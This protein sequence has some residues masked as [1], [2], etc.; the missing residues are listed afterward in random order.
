MKSVKRLAAVV[1]SAFIP[2]CFLVGCGKSVKVSMNDDFIQDIDLYPTQ[3][4]TYAAETDAV[5]NEYWAV[6]NNHT[7]VFGD[8]D[9]DNAAVKKAAIAASSKLF[10][11]ACYNERRLDQ[12]V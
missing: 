3:E 9:T 11:Y 6:A 7:D 10:A 1:A 2:V 5:L 8:V 4:A 12:Y